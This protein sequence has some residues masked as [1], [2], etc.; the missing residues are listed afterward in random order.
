M[1]GSNLS[2]L[3]TGYANH[4]VATHGSSRPSEFWSECSCQSFQSILAPLSA[5]RVFKRINRPGLHNQSR[6]ESTMES[7][8]SSCLFARSLV[9]SPIPKITDANMALQVRRRCGLTSY[10]NKPVFANNSSSLLPLPFNSGISAQKLGQ[11]PILRVPALSHRKGRIATPLAE[12]ST[13][14][15]TLL[16]LAAYTIVREI[17]L[18]PGHRHKNPHDFYCTH[19]G[20]TEI[21]IVPSPFLLSRL[22]CG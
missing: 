6:D 15:V 3:E 13:L 20:R 4:T 10:V 7:P 8:C 11:A 14:S 18:S 12:A 16:R 22:V 19:S 9:S 5:S 1:A 2:A 21:D 17:Q